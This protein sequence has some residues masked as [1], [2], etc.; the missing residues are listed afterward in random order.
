MR[1]A[2]ARIQQSP[3]GLSSEESV[4]KNETKWRQCRKNHRLSSRIP[5]LINAEVIEEWQA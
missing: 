1:K 5:K 4:I 2:Y 3:M